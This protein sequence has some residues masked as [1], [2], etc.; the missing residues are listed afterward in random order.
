MRIRLLSFGKLLGGLFFCAL[1]VLIGLAAASHD[2]FLPP[3]G[4]AYFPLVLATLL[5]GLGLLA[6]VDSLAM[7]D[8]AADDI[9]LPRPPGAYSLATG[10]MLILAIATQSATL[11]L[12]TTAMLVVGIATSGTLRWPETTL[13]AITATTVLAGVFSFEA[14]VPFGQL[15]L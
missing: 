10:C 6:A 7:A 9:A 3:G 13:S 1:G 4:Q 14:H 12:V 15:P 5:L 2:D 8:G 11:A